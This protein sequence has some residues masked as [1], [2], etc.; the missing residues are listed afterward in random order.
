M[1]SSLS[2]LLCYEMGRHVRSWVVSSPV[3]F[4]TRT[5]HVLPCDM[6]FL[7]ARHI[8]GSFTGH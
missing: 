2:F 7:D 6:C 1:V 5:S 8:P 4:V 3:A